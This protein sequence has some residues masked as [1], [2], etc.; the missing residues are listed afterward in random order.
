MINGLILKI[1]LLIIDNLIIS[2]YCFSINDY[3]TTSFSGGGGGG[4][5]SS[6]S[7]TVVDLASQYTKFHTDGW[8]C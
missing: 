5:S 2:F 3:K 6:S 8:T 7:S 4:G 1:L